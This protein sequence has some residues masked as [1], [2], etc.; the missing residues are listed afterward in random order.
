MREGVLPI[1][2][3]LRGKSLLLTAGVSYA[4]LGYAEFTAEKRLVYVQE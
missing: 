1:L 4:F 3:S 2:S